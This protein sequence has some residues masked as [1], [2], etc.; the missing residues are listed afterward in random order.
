MLRHARQLLFLLL[1]AGVSASCAGTPPSARL[2][3]SSTTLIEVPSAEG[4]EAVEGGVL[5][6]GDGQDVMP[7]TTQAIE[8]SKSWPLTGIRDE[9]AGNWPVLI[10]KIDNHDRARPQS[11]INSADVVFE[12]I[13]EG[14]LTR[15]SLIHI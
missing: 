9:Q 11:G 6:S 2:S 8:E 1:V 3:A 10:V 14:G 7:T 15:L 12:E 13:V 4:S 5:D